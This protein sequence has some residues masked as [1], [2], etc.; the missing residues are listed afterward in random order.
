VI[1]GPLDRIVQRMPHVTIGAAAAAALTLVVTLGLP[2]LISATAGSSS[3]TEAAKTYRRLELFGKVF[4]IIRHD[5][6]EKPSGAKLIAS[7]INGMVSGLD[8][9][10]SYM[11]VNDFRNMQV[12]TSGRFG[13]LG[14]QVTMKHG[15][16]EVVSCL[17]DTPAEKAGILAGDVIAKV[18][19]QPIAGL[20]LQQVVTKLRGPPGS[21]VEVEITRQNQ[22]LPIEK[23]VMREIIRVRPVR[24]RIEGDDVGYIEL[25]EFNE[26]AADELKKAIRH[27]SSSIPA[28]QLKGYILDLRNDPGGLLDQ[29]VAVSNVFLDEGQEVVSTRGRQPQDDQRYDAKTGDL[30][31]GKPLIV[32]INGGTASAAEIVSGALQDQ[33]R[34]TIIGTQSFGKGSVQTII[35]LG[36]DNGALRLTT[37]RYYTPSGRSIQA[38]GITPDIEVSEQVPKDLSQNVT[39][40]EAVL[41]GHLKAFGQ[42]ERGSQTYVPPD[43]KED[44]ALQTA[45]GLLRGSETNHAFPPVRKQVVGK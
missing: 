41:R 9:H 36:R 23:T 4:D 44:R 13:G 31:R 38:E 27:I 34:A 39:I 25:S 6:V 8:P 26:L 17:A 20:S 37:A 15:F 21:L 28:D 14:I 45:L 5:Y 29:A 22:A 16:V 43:P 7:A 10:S 18:D 33:K 35:P 11:D 1:V 12:Q 40:S 19:G 42:E 2:P 30:T 24:Y 32:L 3:A